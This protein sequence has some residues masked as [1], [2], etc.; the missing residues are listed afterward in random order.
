MHF[1]VGRKGREAS[2]IRYVFQG[3][4]KEVG[5]EVRPL[6]VRYVFQGREEGA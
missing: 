6:L 4:P 1:R 2:P 5:R 3:T